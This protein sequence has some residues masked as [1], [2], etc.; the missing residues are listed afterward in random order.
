MSVEEIC[1][2]LRAGG[3]SDVTIQAISATFAK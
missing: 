2:E 1:F 3:V